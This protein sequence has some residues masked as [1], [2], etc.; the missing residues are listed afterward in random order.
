MD[1]T[2]VTVLAWQSTC[3]SHIGRIPFAHTQSRKTLKSEIYAAAGL[4]LEVLLQICGI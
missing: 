3:C 1:S 2:E 4:K